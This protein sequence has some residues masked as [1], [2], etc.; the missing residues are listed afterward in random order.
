M[1][2]KV[3]VGKTTCGSHGAVGGPV[4]AGGTG[5]GPGMQVSWSLSVSLDC[6]PCWNVDSVTILIS[7]FARLQMLPGLLGKGPWSATWMSVGE[8]QRSCVSVGSSNLPSMRD[9]SA[10]S[11]V[12]NLGSLALSTAWS[13]ATE[14]TPVGVQRSGSK[15]LL[16]H[17][18]TWNSHTP[19]T[20]PS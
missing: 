16:A 4:V 6:L 19:F 2:S 7:F 20:A 8:V 3:P 18:A 10:W 14:A 15:V 5:G 12:S 13:T 9:C 11:S 1:R 17:A